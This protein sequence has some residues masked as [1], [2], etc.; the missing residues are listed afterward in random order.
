MAVRYSSENLANLIDVSEDILCTICN[1]NLQI[2]DDKVKTRCMHKFHRT[3]ILSW[4]D[5]N[6]T[7]PVCRRAAASSDLS[8]FQLEPASSVAQADNANTSLNN[9][10]GRGAIPR[11]RPQTRSYSRNRGSANTP[12]RTVGNQNQNSSVGSNNRPTIVSLTENRVQ[13][14]IQNSLNEFRLDITSTVANELQT[15]F[16][17]LN[18]ASTG[19]AALPANPNLGNPMWPLD[20]PDLAS[21]PIN[22]SAPIHNQSRNVS[23]DNSIIDTQKISN[24]IS[25]WHIKFTGNSSDITVDDFIYRVN[26][27]TNQSL[28]GNFETLCQYAHLL[29][30]G[31]AQAWYWRFHRQ[32]QNV[33]WNVLCEALRKKYKDYLTDFDIKENMRILKQKTNENF[34]QYL[35]TILALSDKL[36]IAMT[37]RELV[38]TILR[39][40]KPELRHELL[41]L[42]ISDISSLRREAHKHENFFK[43]YNNTQSRGIPM[44]RI[45]SEIVN[46]SD[47][48]E[49][50]LIE[51]M[52]SVAE[53]NSST[54]LKCWNCD[55]LGH[56]YHDCLQTRR[57]FCYGCG[58]LNTYKPSCQKCKLDSENRLSDVRRF[59]R[60]YP[61]PQPRQ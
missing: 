48:V 42:K 53:I 22:R 34:D 7:C 29:F 49:E 45:V 47:V 58:T 35:D 30:G 36:E 28:H 44:R 10:R 51:D 56:R 31:K 6:E 15:L 33:D 16:R 17:D 46:E 60:G 13:T 2:L 40:L 14:L 3:C 20:M 1:E 12:S 43:N 9:S 50:N 27:L 5:G 23:V 61:L 54:Q 41:H 37:E 57:I 11:S 21:Q 38:E 4:L 25:N 55:E 39:N 19:A 18:L 32:S 59:S 26:A 52:P 8:F 24:L